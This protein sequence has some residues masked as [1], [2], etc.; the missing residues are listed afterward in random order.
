MREYYTIKETIQDLHEKV[1][2][3]AGSITQDQRYFADYLYGVK[4]FKPWMEEAENVAKTPLVKPAKLEDALTLLETVKVWRLVQKVFNC[5][6]SVLFLSSF[7][8]ESF[9]WV[10]FLSLFMSS[11][12]V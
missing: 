7:S 5:C 8:L 6:I 1:E 3:E 11:V 10:F 2:M 12:I 9:N 4:N